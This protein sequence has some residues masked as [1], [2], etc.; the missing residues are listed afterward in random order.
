MA[1][2]LEGGDHGLLQDTIQ[3]LSVE[4]E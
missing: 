1:K 4:V 2:D 3:R